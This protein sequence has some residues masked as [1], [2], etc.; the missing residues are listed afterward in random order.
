MAGVGSSVGFRVGS[1]V[2]VAAWATIARQPGPP[3]LRS[4][5][6]KQHAPKARP[7]PRH[8][9]WPARPGPGLAVKGEWL[10]RWTFTWPLWLL[11]MASALLGAIVWFGLGMMRRHRRRKERR[12]A[13]RD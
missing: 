8:D 4:L 12:R 6:A 2:G 11:T 1:S 3:G 5:S 9:R 7:L 10:R 13:R